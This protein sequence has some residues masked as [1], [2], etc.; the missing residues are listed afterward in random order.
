M[1]FAPGLTLPEIPTPAHIDFADI[2]HTT[3]SLRWIPQNFT[4]FTAYRITVVTQGESLPVFQ[5]MVNTAD[6]FYMI[7][8]LEP[9]VEY[10][11]SISSVTEDGESEPT[12][13]TRQTHAGDFIFHSVM[14]L[15]L[16]SER[17]RV[18]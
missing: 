1:H 3:I 8:D 17:T 2:T 4:T 10:V 6:G 14:G 13:Y 15:V 18:S 9:G 16:S 12:T 11:I 5:D 7:H